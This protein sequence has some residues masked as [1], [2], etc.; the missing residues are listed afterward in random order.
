[1][2]LIVAEV[3]SL[4]IV[5]S[6]VFAHRY[7]RHSRGK[8][9]EDSLLWVS[10]A[11]LAYLLFSI[12]FH[13]QLAGIFSLSLPMT[14]I[15]SIF[16]TVTIGAFILMWMLVIEQWVLQSKQALSLL[17]RLQVALFGLFSLASVADFFLHRLFQF[18]GT[19]LSGGIGVSL[20]LL[21]S[22]FYILIAMVCLVVRWRSVT[23][24]SRLLFSLIISFL[25]LSLLFFQLFRQPYLLALSSSFILL[26]SYLVWQRKELTLDR[27]TRI[28]N[29][30][31]FYD[32][33]RH[34]TLHKER[35][36]LLM[37]DI[38]N[39]RLV[40]E[41]HGYTVGDEL[42]KVFATFLAELGGAAYRMV[43]NRFVLVFPH[44]SHNEIV[45]RVQAIRSRT[46][47]GWEIGTLHLGFHV[48]IAIAETPLSLNT[49]D[50][51]VESLEFTL[52]AIKEKRR[53]PVII[54][55]Q[56]LIHLRQ[57]RLEVLSALRKAVVDESQI[58]IHY[59][60][61]T[62]I[63]DNRIFAAEAL[64]RLHDERL[65][66][67][68]PTE[69]I[70]LAE[71]V[72]LITK[73]TEVVLKKV[74]TVLSTSQAAGLALSHIS[75]NISAEDLISA[76]AAQHLLQIMRDYKINPSLIRFEVTESMLLSP[77]ETTQAVW[78]V[79]EEAGIHFL[80]DDF[81]TG[82]ANLETL[83]ERPFST[84]KIDRSVVSNTRNQYQL[85]NVIAGMLITLG[86]QMVAEGVETEAQLAAIRE[87]GIVYVQGYYYS[88]PLPEK[89]FIAY[90]A[91]S[92]SN[93][94]Q[95]IRTKE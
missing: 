6:I 73:L 40:N 45:R 75:I 66:M 42:L 44:L 43:G 12:L 68:S 72:G 51:V 18:D 35:V 85:L 20:V 23:V 61:I 62:D 74:C 77:G 53:Y 34:T 92:G 82:Y 91:G 81:G 86:K 94:H 93:P 15:L 28:P 21:L 59:Q 95:K 1:M 31:A 71:Q 25:F 38:E 5:S 64:M 4:I 27:L 14:R 41:R 33:L 50:E 16:H 10:Y 7:T 69:F 32:K 19:R 80:L 37:V 63:R 48:N 55:N 83:V 54:F 9:K 56:K 87:A 67:I 22:S 88:K 13:L 79:Y 36:T 26:L 11:S 47:Q 78:K 30:Q 76:D 8:T 3:L 70:P 52:A 29:Y 46:A 84:V 2:E 39:F 90:L 49:A 17:T 65:G 89:D 60:P 57:R 58:L 24:F